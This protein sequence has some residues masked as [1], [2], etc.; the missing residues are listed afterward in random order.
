MTDDVQTELLEE[1]RKLRLEVARL[2]AEVAK[3]QL[4][5]DCKRPFIGNRPHINCVDTASRGEPVIYGGTE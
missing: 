3:S 5:R 4:C 2:K 1:N